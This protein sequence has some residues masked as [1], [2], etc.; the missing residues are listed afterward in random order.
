MLH[1]SALC[2]QLG[3]LIKNEKE[4]KWKNNQDKSHHWAGQTGQQSSQYIASTRQIWFLIQRER[5]VTLK[6]TNTCVYV[7]LWASAVGS[8][9][10]F[11]RPDSVLHSLPAWCKVIKGSWHWKK[12]GQGSGFLGQCFNY[13]WLTGLSPSREGSAETNDNWLPYHWKEHHSH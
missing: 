12:L 10:A 4:M 1:N 3:L 9:R 11:S 7:H 6:M 13:W 5:M 2:C 8:T